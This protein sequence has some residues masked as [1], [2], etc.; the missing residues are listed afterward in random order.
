M[1]PADEAEF[2]QLWQQGASYRDIAQAL[3][4]PLGTVASRSAAL[5]AQGKIQPRPRRPP[6]TRDI[7]LPYE[8]HPDFLAWK[9]RQAATIRGWH[10]D[11]FIFQ[12]RKRSE[13][14]GSRPI[15]RQHLWWLVKGAV[16]RA[17]LIDSTLM[18]PS[19]YG[20]HSMR[21]TAINA[22]NELT[23]DMG[24]AAKFANHRNRATT[25]VYLEVDPRLI[26]EAV[27]QNG[28]LW[29]AA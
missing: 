14:G 15:S 2:I 25:A 21:C 19:K 5:A 7:P 4:C 27:R 10:Y 22:V 8:L 9:A 24:K 20:T 17:R 11:D 13:T 6:D 28:A 1:T 18:D 26:E 29:L 12:S 23:K 3:G 16:K